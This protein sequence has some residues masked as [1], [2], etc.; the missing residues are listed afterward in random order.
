MISGNRISPSALD[1]VGIL[2][3]GRMTSLRL[4]AST[5]S[6]I[7]ILGSLIPSRFVIKSSLFYF[8]DREELVRGVTSSLFHM[9][10]SNE[11]FDCFSL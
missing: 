7:V 8:R 10:L 11:W 5:T 9:I 6:K 1:N 3:Q 4:P 2:E